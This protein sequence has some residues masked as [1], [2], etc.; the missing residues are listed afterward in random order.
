MSE[1]EEQQVRNRLEVVISTEIKH[2]TNLEVKPGDPV[3]VVRNGQ[4]VGTLRQTVLGYDPA[5]ALL[6]AALV[7]DEME[8]KKAIEAFSRVGKAS[9]ALIRSLE[10]VKSTGWT[11][12]DPS[13]YRVLSDAL[14]PADGTLAERIIRQVGIG[15]SA[16]IAAHAL[17]KLADGLEGQLANPPG[18]RG[19]KKN[20]AAYAVARELARLFARVTGEKPTFS[21]SK[22]VP[23][24]QYTPALRAVF[25]AL[26]WEKTDLKGPAN[27]AV[28]S[29]TDA[30]LQHVKNRPLWS[31]LTRPAL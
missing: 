16:E 11:P 1:Q 29:I 30:D 18:K 19:A 7:D 3:P 15:T 4:Q 31:I 5:R 17:I 20:A 28:Q 21:V 12:S 22:G 2:W 14:L 24:G 6:N 27:D 13:A 9:K 8:K 26:G 25:D 10:A 23:A